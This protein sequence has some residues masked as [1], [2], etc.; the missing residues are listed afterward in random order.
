MNEAYGPY[1]LTD[2]PFPPDSSLNLTHTDKRINGTIFNDEI[3][4][5]ELAGLN[6]R[7][8]RRM[9]L[10]Y[11]QNTSEFVRGVGKSAIIAHAWRR[12]RESG[13]HVTAVY[14]Q[15]AKRHTPTAL[16]RQ[17]ISEWHHEGFLWSVLT[18]S[19]EG[20]VE[21]APSPEITPEGAKLLVQ[22]K[23]P[24]DRVDLRAFLCYNPSR[25]MNSLT[26]WACAERKALS[27]EI[28]GRFFESYLANPRE[29]L[30]EYPKV[31]RKF[32]WDEIE[33]LRA[34]LELM[35]LGGFEYHHLFFD[36]FEDA[37]H[38]LRG[39]DLIVF[40]S[41][42]RR[43]LEA[44]IGRMSIIV[45]LHPGAVTTLEAPEGQEFVTLAPLDGRHRVDVEP[46]D[47]SDAQALA[48]T[49]L[50]EFRSQ[51]PPEP[52]FPLSPEAVSHIHE[53]AEGNIRE[54]LTGFNLCIEEGVDAGHPPITLD[55]LHS[56]HEEITGRI[57]PERISLV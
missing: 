26:D 22:K 48:I 18:Q 40:S 39:K 31:L 23:W 55:F 3:F 37:I 50:E 6:K 12:L 43:L 29:F 7:L 56:R 16:S 35:D 20:Y 4:E 30:A 19:L 24:V 53:M 25:L 1:Y 2:N 17:V 57:S 46:P 33:M 28:A 8:G 49:Y 47:S 14:I 10:I 27:P 44:G 11:C 36:Q 42:M 21:V 5:E 41:E 34:G 45:T 15:S 54:I 13:G 52:L 9:N 38:G 51:A 32:K